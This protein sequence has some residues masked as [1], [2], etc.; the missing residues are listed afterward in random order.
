MN[1]YVEDRAKRRAKVVRPHRYRSSSKACMAQS[2][3][4]FELAGFRRLRFML[5]GI[6]IIRSSVA[7]SADDRQDDF[8]FCVRPQIPACISDAS[9]YRSKSANG[10]CQTSV[11]RY[12]NE[13]LTY[14]AC[15]G[16]ELGRIN[17]Q[18]NRVIDYLKCR[19]KHDSKCPPF[20]VPSPGSCTD[21]SCAFEVELNRPAKKP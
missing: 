3:T 12:I 2:G 8:D 19:S 18:A 21:G 16:R 4:D 14:R 10:A 7:L 11:S 1:R 20:H 9:T 5:F 15:V 6:L 13:A 17:L